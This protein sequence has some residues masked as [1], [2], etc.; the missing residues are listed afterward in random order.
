MKHKFRL[1]KINL[2]VFFF[3]CAYYLLVIDHITDKNR[4]DFKVG[5]RLL[6]ILYTKI[7]LKTNK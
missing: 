4:K 6:T 7:L 5:D 3:R 1:L 2:H